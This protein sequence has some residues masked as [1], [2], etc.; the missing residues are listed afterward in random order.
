MAISAEMVKQL[1]V[2]TGAGIMDCKKALQEADGDID[3]A[4]DWL[5]KKGMA[6]AKKRAERVT[7]EGMIDSYI[8]PGNRVGVLIEINCETD[9]VAKN[10]EFKQFVHNMAMQVAAA[11][12]VVVS[13]EEIPQESI[14]REMNIYKEQAKAT[15]K[16][17]HILEK[18]AQGKLEKYYQEV[19]LMEQTYIRDPEKTIENLLTDLIAKIGENINIRRF[20]RYQLGE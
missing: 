18:I 15:G 7:K 11:N 5:R 13:R 9:F 12:P 3:K 2:K 1:R 10:D 6:S 14:D 4:S 17:D 20:V 19:C 16:P 8:H